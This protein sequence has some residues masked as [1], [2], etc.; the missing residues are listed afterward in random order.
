MVPPDNVEEPPLDDSD[1]GCDV[2]FDDG[3]DDDRVAVDGDE[4]L[5]EEVRVEDGSRVAEV[6]VAVES[7]NV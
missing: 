4:L 3:R 7:D 2:D 5:I 1:D 6:V